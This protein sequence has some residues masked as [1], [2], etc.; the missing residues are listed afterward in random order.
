MAY[1]LL[2]QLHSCYSAV[3]TIDHMAFWVDRY[4]FN[5]FPLHKIH[6]RFVFQL[7]MTLTL[8]L[9]THHT[10]YILCYVA[11]RPCV[12]MSPFC[13]FLVLIQSHGPRKTIVNLRLK[14]YLPSTLVLLGNLT[15]C[16]VSAFYTNTAVVHC[17]TIF[18]L[19]CKLPTKK[20][21][22]SASQGERNYLETHQLQF[23]CQ[24]WFAIFFI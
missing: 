1:G 7:C 24:F 18:N 10:S 22:S 17:S 20:N 15:W 14:S 12:I 23:L 5:T 13:N 3:V 4:H 16:A 8:Q 21:N 9:E 6:F 2:L 11:I 19:V